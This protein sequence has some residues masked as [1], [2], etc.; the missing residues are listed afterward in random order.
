M[1]FCH[2]SRQFL[3]YCDWH[4]L[5]KAYFSR[6]RVQCAIIALINRFYYTA[7]VLHKYEAVTKFLNYCRFSFI[8]W[9]NSDIIFCY[10][11]YCISEIVWLCYFYRFYFVIISFSIKIIM[12]TIFYYYSVMYKIYSNKYFFNRILFFPSRLSFWDMHY[13]L[14]IFI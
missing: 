12:L 8:I 6:R 9:Y 11:Y 10:R 2:I 4:G 3:H 7:T 5:N 1:V 14:D 13:V